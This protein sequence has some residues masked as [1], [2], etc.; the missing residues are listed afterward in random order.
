MI[1]YLF[2]DIVKFL[3]NK[4]Q[5]ESSKILDEI[6]IEIV[7]K[8]STCTVF[9][10]AGA[11]Q[12]DTSLYIQSVLPNC[13]VFAFEANTYNFVRFS[14]NFQNS[15][16]LYVN[17]ALSDKDGIITFKIQKEINGNPVTQI[18]GNNSILPRVGTTFVYEDATVECTTL[19]TF[20]LGKLNH[21]DCISL[22]LDL[23]GHAFEVLT[24]SVSVLEKTS[25]I[26]IEVE[27]KQW[28]EHQ[29][30]AEDIVSFLTDQKFIPIIRDFQ[31]NKQ[32]NI[33]FCKKE[34]IEN[35]EFETVFK[36]LK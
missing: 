9:V 7:T 4:T 19:D 10:E 35:A 20:F 24:R 6:F 12:G 22:W 1:D 3:K 8:I 36:K 34:I 16:V 28:W 32:Y 14:P 18:R 17:K 15:K 25:C 2:P 33:L 31:Y 27:E 30:L 26:K 13:K 29:K 5:E 23:E 11:F 21:D